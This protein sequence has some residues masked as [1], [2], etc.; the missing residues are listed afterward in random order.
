[1][2]WRPAISGLRSAEQ[3]R[4]SSNM[5]YE[6]ICFEMSWESLKES[7]WT[8][9]DWWHHV[10]CVWWRPLEAE[11]ACFSF[12]SEWT[13]WARY[14]VWIECFRWTEIKL[15]ICVVGSV[16]IFSSQLKFSEAVYESSIVK[17]Q[18]RNC[19]NS[20]ILQLRRYVWFLLH[21]VQ[22]YSAQTFEPRYRK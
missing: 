21:Q 8:T 10:W 18:K 13:H 17:R 15:S 19:K 2:C 3:F 14:E 6:C 4:W 5:K 1:V 7:V 22:L 20:R 9:Y 12:N 11:I 16:A